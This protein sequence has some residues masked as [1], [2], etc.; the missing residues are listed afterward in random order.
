MISNKPQNTTLYTPKSP[1]DLN[2]DF[3]TFSYHYMAKIS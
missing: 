3:N 1:I 2:M